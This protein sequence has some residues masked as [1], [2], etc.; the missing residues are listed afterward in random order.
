[1]S[2]FSMTIGVPLAAKSYKQKIEAARVERMMQ[3]MFRQITV[4]RLETAAEKAWQI[5]QGSEDALDFYE[6]TGLG[7]AAAII[8]SAEEAYRA[9]EISFADMSQFLVQAITI[10][11][12]YLDALNKYNGNANEYNYLLNNQ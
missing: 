3:E 8:S 1:V 4:Q 5:L 6:T 7:Q 9:G 2:G 11:E 12:K 10:R